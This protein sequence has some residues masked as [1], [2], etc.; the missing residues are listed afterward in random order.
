MTL[1]ISNRVVCTELDALPHFRTCKE[2]STASSRLVQRQLLVLV[3]STSVF[4][5]L[6]AGAMQYETDDE[7]LQLPPPPLKWK[8]VITAMVAALGKQSEYE[9]GVTT[10]KARL[11]LLP[12]ETAGIAAE[13]RLVAANGVCFIDCLGAL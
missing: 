11:F 10:P 6:Y 5:R 13:V 12:T 3:M 2:V 8:D 9:D 4:V 1:E 7:V